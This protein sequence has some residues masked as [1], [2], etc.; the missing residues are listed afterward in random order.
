MGDIN[1]S[2]EVLKAAVKIASD[3]ET[4]AFI[5]LALAHAM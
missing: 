2:I 1:G 4:D 3:K 5:Q